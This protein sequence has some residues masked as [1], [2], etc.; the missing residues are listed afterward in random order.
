M[1]PAA[2]GAVTSPHRVI[3][4]KGDVLEI[5]QIPRTQREMPFGIRFLPFSPD[6]RSSYSCP[7][8]EVAQIC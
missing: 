8:S 4:H 5:N 3:A 2:W 1:H 6:G 7:Q